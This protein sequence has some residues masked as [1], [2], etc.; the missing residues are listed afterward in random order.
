MSA[1][2]LLSLAALIVNCIFVRFC[3]K[4]LLFHFNCQILILTLVSMNIVH[5]A[6]YLLMLTVHFKKM[7]TVYENPC[8]VMSDG[9]FCFTV[10]LV[11][12]SCY[13]GHTTVFFG[14][15]VER[16]LATRYMATY[17]RSSHKAGYIIAFCSLL[18][19]FLLSCFKMRLF[20]M[21]R[22]NMYCSA[23]TAETYTDVLVTH[24]LLLALLM[25]T[26]IIFG[27]IF[28]KNRRV[29]NSALQ[30]SIPVSVLLLCIIAA[31]SSIHYEE[32]NDV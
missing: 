23:I 10:R 20:N 14:L 11:T 27:S 31:Y 22:R 7:T 25:I 2:L 1:H 12:A 4:K 29:T 9:R 5:S 13:I 24:G 30:M 16:F 19:A 18:S 32:E 15:L 28:F 3:L 8:D 17:E 26:V 21:D 6:M